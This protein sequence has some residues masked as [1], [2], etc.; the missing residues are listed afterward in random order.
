VPVSQAIIRSGLFSS[1]LTDT[2]TPSSLDVEQIADPRRA[3][4]AFDV[5]P[6]PSATELP[7]NSPTRDFES[8]SGSIPVGRFWRIERHATCHA[9]RASLPIIFAGNTARQAVGISVG[10][11]SNRRNKTV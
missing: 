6:A 10:T 9:P 8:E 2:A 3:I 1:V 7:R 4:R 11:G 5:D